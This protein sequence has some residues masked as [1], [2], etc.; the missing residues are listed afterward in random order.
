MSQDLTVGGA[1]ELTAT[2][3]VDDESA[4]RRAMHERHAQ[5]GDGERS[6]EDGTHGPAEHPSGADV[7]DGN[8]IEPALA[9]EDA[10][11]IGDPDLVGTLHFEVLEAVGCD[12]AA[13]A[14]VGGGVAILGALPGKEAL[15]THEPGDA[16]APSWTTQRM[17]QARTAGSPTTAVELLMD[18]GAEMSVLQLP[19][20]RLVTPFFPVVITA[21]RDQQRFAQPRHFVLA[22]H[23]F[24]SGIPL[25]GTSER[26]PNDF[27]STSRCSNSFAF[28]C[29]KRWFSASNCSTLRLGLRPL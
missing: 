19:R 13:V 21:A 16:I 5:S 8:Q 17:G 22:A 14:A 7:Q 29:R 1:G 27:F 18:T 2:I 25:D 10:G 24:D 6:I 9:G 3:G 20:P 11:G 15:G 28:S 12:G 23:H 4:A 26:M